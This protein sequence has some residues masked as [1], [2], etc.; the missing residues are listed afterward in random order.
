MDE[1]TEIDSESYLN[2]LNRP[3]CLPYKLH[4]EYDPR[5]KDLAEKVEKDVREASK[6]AGIEQLVEIKLSESEQ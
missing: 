1:P 3:K 6:S 2:E 4:I 5:S